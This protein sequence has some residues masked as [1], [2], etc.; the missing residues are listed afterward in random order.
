ML[1]LDPASPMAR[2]FYVWVLLLNGR[3]DEISPIVDGLSA[4]AARTVPG[5]IALFLRAALATA[6]GDALP[7][8]DGDIEI[9]ARESDVFARTLADA[10]AIAGLS[11]QAISWLEVAVDRG[12]INYPF[13]AKVNPILEPLRGDDG[14]RRLIERVHTRWE[15]FE[16]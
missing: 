5:R 13:L 4:D 7:T 8:I 6:N 9:A 1:H 12:F 10:Y 15:R 3:R 16:V 2:L 14:F 11:E